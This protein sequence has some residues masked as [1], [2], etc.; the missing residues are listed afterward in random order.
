[1][2]IAAAPRRDILDF[3]V[4]NILYYVAEPV[5]DGTSPTIDLANSVVSR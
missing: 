2:L 3:C 5:G 1:M 4:F